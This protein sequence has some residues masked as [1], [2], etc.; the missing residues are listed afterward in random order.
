[1][2]RD[3]QTEFKD[4]CLTCKKYDIYSKSDATVRGFR[5]KRLMRQM[6]L[7][8]HC[9]QYDC[10]KVRGNASIEEAV[11]WLLK[12]GYEPRYDCYI[13]T[14]V[15]HI[16][17]LPLDCEY[18]QNFRKLRDNYVAKLPNGADEL[19]SYDIY[20][21]QIANK[22][23]N[24][25]QNEETKEATKKM[26]E[27]VLFPEFIELVNNLIKAGEYETAWFIYSA[28]IELLSKRYNIVY[29][30]PPKEEKNPLA[31]EEYS[32]ALV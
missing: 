32:R 30:V 15:C 31:Q 2:A 27:E 10:D 5:C 8:D 12:R 22:L 26:A 19:V 14:A 4:K 16:K 17:G 28:M 11:T 9:Y 7:D 1:M 21:I 23:L 29:Y 13:T 20:G 25:Y 3:Y 18:V 6:A 24:D